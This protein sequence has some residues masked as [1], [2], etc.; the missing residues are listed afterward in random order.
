[1]PSEAIILSSNMPECADLNFSYLLRFLGL[2][3]FFQELEPKQDQLNYLGRITDTKDL[4]IVMS[5]DTLANLFTNNS[6]AEDVKGHLFK[7][8]SYIL[9]Y[10]LSASGAHNFAIQQ[11]TDKNILS[12]SSLD[13]STFNYEISSDAKGITKELSGMTFGPVNNLTDHILSLGNDS[14]DIFTLVSINRKPFFILVKKNYCQLF[15]VACR[16][17]IDINEK[18]TNTINLKQFFSKSVPHLMFLKHVFKDMCWH[19]RETCATVIIDDPLLRERYGFLKYGELIQAM[20]NCDFS[21][22]IAFIPWNFKRTSRGV[23]KLFRERSD[24]LSLCVHGCDHTEAEFGESDPGKLD[25]KVNVATTRMETHKEITGIE[26]DKVMVFPQGYFSRNVM[27]TLKTNN[28]SA[29]ANSTPYPCDQLSAT[30]RI[31]DLFDVAIMS[32]EN[33]P[34]FV[35]RY[36]KNLADFAFDAFLGKPIL[37]V[38]HHSDFRAGYKEIVIFVKTINSISESIRWKGV[39]EAIRTTYLER[40]GSDGCTYYKIYSNDV[41]ITNECFHDKTYV[42]LKAEKNDVPIRDVLIN[43]KSWPYEF[44]DDIL[45]VRGDL[46]GK[47]VINIKIIYGEANVQEFYR[48]LLTYRLKVLI[49]RYLSE[50][51]DNYLCKKTSLVVIGERIARFVFSKRLGN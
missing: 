14:K 21:S 38:Q 5:G 49:R 48:A 26:F 13:N 46:K 22:S 47:G 40:I 11:L 3:Y 43:G 8:M 39:G 15:I 12:I 41:K 37:I 35:R 34:L 4:C 29:A 27:R 31:L 23:A 30:L 51:R 42:I 20:D 45:K 10:G 44:S 18:V 25:Q 33:F 24:R 7:N 28:Y 19:A 32:H 16:E 50:F 1:M 9:V 36:P 2:R 6:N 17:V